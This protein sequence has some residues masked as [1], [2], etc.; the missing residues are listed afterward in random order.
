VAGLTKPQLNNLERRIEKVF[1]KAPVIPLM[2]PIPFIEKTMGLELDSWQREYIN[3]APQNKR[4]AICC[5]RQSGKSTVTAGYVAWYMTYFPGVLILIASKSL[6]QASHYLEKVA[7]CLTRV[8]NR[9]SIPMMNR[10]TIGLSNGSMAVSIP[11]AN[12]DTARG[13]SPSLVVLDES[14][15]VGEEMMAVITPSLA[16]TQGA[17]HMLSS[18]NGPQG[19]FYHA[20]EGDNKEDYW[21][22]KVTW[23]DCPRIDPAFIE[24]EKRTLGDI[25]FRSEYMAEFLSAQGAFFGYQGLTAFKSPDGADYDALGVTQLTPLTPEETTIVSEDLAEAMDFRKRVQRVLYAS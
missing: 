11:A 1:T 7:G 9:D 22:L 21:S 4:V 12:P 6:R 20:I 24:L 16:A 5:S 8:Y 3:A 14:A 15:F 13:F 10:L 17:I 23:K 19:P 18:A 2:R 25:R